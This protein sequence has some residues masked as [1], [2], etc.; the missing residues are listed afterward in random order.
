M[1]YSMPKGFFPQEDTGLIFGFTQADQ[2]ISF[3]GMASR[4]DAVSQVIGQDPDVAAFGSSIGGSGSSGMNTGRIFIQLKPYSQREATADQIIQRLRPKL[5]AVPGIS[6]FLQSIQNIQVGA[7]LARTQYQYT[8]QDI[9]LDE[10]NAWAPKVLAKLKTLPALQ[11]VASDQETGSSRLMIKINR[12]S[13]ARLGVNVTTIQQTRCMTPSANRT[14]PSSMGHS[15]PIMSFSR[16]PRSTRP[17]SLRCRESTCMRP[18][19]G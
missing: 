14:S 9:D 19:D 1:F 10:L 6:T 12:D 15:T 11:D 18:A 4:E 13:A 3:D 7:R 2:D 16:S 8:L 5:G 17:M